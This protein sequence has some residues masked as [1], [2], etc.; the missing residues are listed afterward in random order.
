M[1]ENYDETAKDDAYVC[2]L[3]Q[4]ERIYSRIRITT[5]EVLKEETSELNCAI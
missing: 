2:F 1:K 5:F 3:K 4:L